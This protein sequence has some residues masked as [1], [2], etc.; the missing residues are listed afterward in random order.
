MV[1][2]GILKHLISCCQAKGQP[3]QF[4]HHRPPARAFHLA[5]PLGSFGTTMSLTQWLAMIDG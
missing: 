5:S 1:A 2:Y 4:S 3:S